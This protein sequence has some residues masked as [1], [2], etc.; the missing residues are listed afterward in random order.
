MFVCCRT[1]YNFILHSKV[2]LREQDMGL[3]RNQ[4]RCMTCDATRSR[5]GTYGMTR[6][7]HNLPTEY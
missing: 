4:Q 7:F 3:V 2:A 1:E 5:I 6:G